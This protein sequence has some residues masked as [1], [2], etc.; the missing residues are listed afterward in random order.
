MKTRIY[1]LSVLIL[2]IGIKARSQENNAKGFAVFMENFAL[3]SVFQKQH[4]IF[5]LEYRTWVP[6]E[7]DEPEVGHIQKKDWQPMAF[8]PTQG[9][10]KGGP[11]YGDY[12]Q[13]FI[14]EA[15]HTT[16]QLR[17]VDNGI[18]TDFIFKRDNGSWY[19]LRV[20]DYST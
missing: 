18:Y 17:G 12:T 5:P 11:G 10:K 1:I 16:I 6:G 19:L 15:T 3:D 4:T 7:G 8:E 2:V 9:L 14:I 13:Q 20:E